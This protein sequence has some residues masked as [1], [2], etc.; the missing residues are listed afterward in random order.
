MSD[1][2]FGKFY[3]PARLAA[4]CD[5][6]DA[7][8][9]SFYNLGVALRLVAYA[10][11]RPEEVGDLRYGDMDLE[12]KVIHAGEK[13][14]PM[15]KEVE[16]ALEDWQTGLTAF[17]VILEEEDTVF[18]YGYSRPGTPYQ[19]PRAQIKNIL[20]RAARNACVPASRI[21]WLRLH[22]PAMWVARGVF[23]SASEAVALA[24]IRPVCGAADPV[25]DVEKYA[26]WLSSQPQ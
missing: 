14:V 12:C 8:D 3:T 25:G 10:G 9:A 23:R 21:S 6:A 1:L 18:A 15:L 7:G 5:A 2:V 20:L 19:R 16:D 24:E 26:E 11:L 4:L 17:S 13:I 22:A